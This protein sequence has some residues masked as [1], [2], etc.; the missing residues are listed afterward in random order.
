VIRNACLLPCLFS[1]SIRKKRIDTLYTDMT[2]YEDADNAYIGRGNQG[3][4][5]KM[6]RICDGQVRDHPTPKLTKRFANKVIV[7]DRCTKNCPL[8]SRSHGE[9]GG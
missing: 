5:R 1:L 2:T 6:R 7:L 9:D 4:V 8:L 3:E